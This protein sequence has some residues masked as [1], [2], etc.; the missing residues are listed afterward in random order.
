MWL[1]AGDG[2]WD[3]GW[4]LNRATCPAPALPTCWG[5]SLVCALT[6]HP[7]FNIQLRYPRPLLYLSG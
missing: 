4:G 3:L 6:P 5:P 1:R 7:S 2:R